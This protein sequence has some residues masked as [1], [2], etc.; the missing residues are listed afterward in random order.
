MDPIEILIDVFCAVG[1]RL[2]LI[3]FF[4]CAILTLIIVLLIK[5]SR[6]K[7]K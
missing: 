5:V 1:I 2:L 4:I 6:H 3:G 7:V